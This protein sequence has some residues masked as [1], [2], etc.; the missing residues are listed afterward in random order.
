MRDFLYSGQC[1]P[2]PLPPLLLPATLQLPPAPGSPSFFQLAPGS[3]SLLQLAP[4]SPSFLQLA[5]GSPSLLQL[6]P[7]SPSFLQLTPGSPSLLQLQLAAAPLPRR[8][9]LMRQPGGRC[10]EAVAQRVLGQVTHGPRVHLTPA[11]HL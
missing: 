1:P 10:G 4:G 6:A 11:A 9:H 8:Q 5:P 2:P 7:G 3:P